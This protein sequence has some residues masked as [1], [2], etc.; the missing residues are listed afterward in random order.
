MKRFANLPRLTLNWIKTARSHELLY[1]P[2]MK[3]ITESSVPYNSFIFIVNFV[4][5]IRLPPPVLIYISINR[6][7]VNHMK[8]N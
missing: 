3:P 6:V 7:Q 2:E 4:K 5:D 8:L 1:P